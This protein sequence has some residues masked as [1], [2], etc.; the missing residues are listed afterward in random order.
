MNNKVI[1]SG[2]D[3]AN[4]LNHHFESVSTKYDA[5]P[6]SHFLVINEQMADI[7]SK[8]ESITKQLQSIKSNKSPAPEEIPARVL[9]ELTP[10]LAP[11]LEVIF[12]K[13]LSEGKLPHDWKIARVAPIF[14]KGNRQDPGNYRPIFLTSLSCKILEHI[15]VSNIMTYL[16]SSN[17]LH[18]SQHDFCKYRSCE[19]QLALFLQDILKSSESKKTSTMLNYGAR[20]GVSSLISVNVQQCT[21]SKSHYSDN[22]PSKVMV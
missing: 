12:V 2:I 22:I 9:T 5:P 14:K 19:T 8:R 6:G 16:D 11:Y 20:S 10:Q 3:K 15:I 17:F 1:T 18:T 4:T 13:S 7:I 21:S